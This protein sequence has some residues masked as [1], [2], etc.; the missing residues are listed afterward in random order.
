MLKDLG[1]YTFAIGKNHWFPQKSLLGYCGTL[2]DESGRVETEDFI[3]D[4]RIWFQ[5]HA[6]GKN[7]DAT[8]IGWNEHKAA[9]YKLDEKLHPTWWTGQM[10]CELLRNYNDDRPL[11]LKVSFARPHSPYDPPKRI[12]DKYK[13]MDVPKPVIGDWCKKYEA[14]K[15]PD[16][17]AKDAAFANFGDEYVINSKRHYYANIT[18]IDE[19]IGKIID[20]LKQRNMYD[21]TLICYVSDHGDMMGDHYHWRKTYAYEGSTHIPFIIKWPASIQHCIKKVD[22]TVELRDLLPTFLELAG[23][24]VPEDM[25]GK[26]LLSLATQKDCKWRDY[27][28]LEHSTCYDPDNYW[29]ALTDGKMKYIWFFHSGR[30]QL[31]NLTD[32]PGETRNLSAV[33]SYRK[34]LLNWRSRMV[35]YL[36]ERGDGF[37]RD[38]KL[39]VRKEDMLYSPNYPK[40]D[41]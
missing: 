35:D 16:E 6:P 41:K 19:Q 21:N 40:T 13:N 37:V 29:C 25:D 17:V 38:G 15:N 1:Y 3:S 24:T 2:V 27:L 20:V 34:T 32:D 26:S 28:G 7:P 22:K 31:F 12:Y 30:E 10:A 8:G 11:F 36:S 9:V 4:Y 5:L 14:L 33:K 18:F 23:G 39:V